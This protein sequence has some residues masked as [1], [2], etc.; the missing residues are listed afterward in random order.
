MNPAPVSGV[1]R[2]AA[3]TIGSRAY[4]R[5]Q[6]AT[7]RRFYPRLLPHAPR[8]GPVG[9]EEHRA[10][11]GQL[12]FV[13]HTLKDRAAFLA[14]VE[15]SGLVGRGGAG[16]PTAR[17]LKAIDGRRPVV[18]ANGTEGEPLSQKDKLLLSLSPQ[19][20]LDGTVLVAEA[21]DALEAYVVVHPAVVLTAAEAVAQRRSVD[22]H[23]VKLTVLPAQD[24]YVAGEASA[25]ANYLENGVARPRPNPPR[26]VERG[27]WGRPTLVNNVETL[28][29]IALLARYGAEWFRSAGTPDEPGSMLVTLRGAVRRPVVTEVEMGTPVRDLLALAGGPTGRLQALLIGGYFG[30]FVDGQEAVDR[31]YSRAGLAGL[32]ADV[33]AGVVVAFD[34]Q[35]C[36]VVEAARIARYLAGQSAGQCGPCVFGLAAVAEELDALASGQLTG[37]TARLERWLAEVE[38]RGAC[39]LPDGATR[40]VASA[41][42]VFSDEVT[43][44]VSGRCRPGAR[45]HGHPVRSRQHETVRC[46]QPARS[47]LTGGPDR[48]RRLRFLC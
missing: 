26:L 32:D 40:L 1:E 33:G 9:A 48:L 34:D 3:A 24:R 44:H 16:F 41:L 13:G 36:G 43:A 8:A 28:A 11:L 23:G 10:R 17:K 5:K 6:T 39:H 30:S 2:V 22:N 31:P 35:T 21:L 46:E 18:I 37:G 29:H 38:G 25:L 27:A 4:D 20:V 7:G 45:R 14:M 12:P 19:L 42:R 47:S 15:R